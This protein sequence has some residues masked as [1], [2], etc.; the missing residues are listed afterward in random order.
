MTKVGPK[1]VTDGL[2][3]SFN[4]ETLAMFSQRGIPVVNEVT[5]AS[6]YTGNGSNYGV[7]DWTNLL[8]RTHE[9]NIATPD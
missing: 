2:E 1:V 9:P 5:S 4:F 3:F 6:D 7:Q 8:I